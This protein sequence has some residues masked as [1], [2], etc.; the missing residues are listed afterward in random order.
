MQRHGHEHEA[1]QRSRGAGKCHEERL[2]FL[3]Q[4]LVS[5]NCSF[6]YMPPYSPERM[7]ALST[8]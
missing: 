1:S 5:H 7:R 3:Y 4:D 2:P 6:T 8:S